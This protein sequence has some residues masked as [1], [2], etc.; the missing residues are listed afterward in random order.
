LTKSLYLTP[1]SLH[2]HDGLPD[3]LEVR[4]SLRE[5]DVATAWRAVV[6]VVGDASEAA[7]HERPPATER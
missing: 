6:V 2:P 7:S 1:K 4:I 5:G 3:L